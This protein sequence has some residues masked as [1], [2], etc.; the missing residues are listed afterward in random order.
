MCMSQS[1]FDL[2]AVIVA[3]HNAM[4]AAGLLRVLAPQLSHHLVVAVCVPDIPHKYSQVCMFQHCS[5]DEF[6]VHKG[7]EIKRD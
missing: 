6:S 1:S 2:Q 4:T 7:S 3:G 5:S